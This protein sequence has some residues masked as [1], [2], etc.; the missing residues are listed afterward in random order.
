M[1]ADRMSVHSPTKVR[2]GRHRRHHRPFFI[3]GAAAAA[4]ASR[5]PSPTDLRMVSICARLSSAVCPIGP[6]A[7]TAVAR[8]LDAFAILS[9][10]VA[11]S[12]VTYINV[13]G[14]RVSHVEA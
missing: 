13:A 8:P 5:L 12:G 1:R 6:P 10:C 7:S 3:S 14:P 9:R 11:S 4:A 2:K